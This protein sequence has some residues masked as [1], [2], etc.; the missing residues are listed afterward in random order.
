MNDYMWIFE[1]FPVDEIQVT[2]DGP[3]EVHDKRRIGSKYEELMDS[4]SRVLQ[5]NRIHTK[6]RVNVDT[7]NTLPELANDIIKRQLLNCKSGQASIC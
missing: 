2:V 1:E 4:I 6:L 7:A 3:Y 5:A